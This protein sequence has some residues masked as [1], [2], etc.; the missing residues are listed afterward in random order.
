MTEVIEDAEKVRLLPIGSIVL[1]CDSDT[2][3]RYD[4]YWKCFTG[5]D[6]ILYGDSPEQYLPVTLIH[7]GN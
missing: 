7:R 4:A 6:D 3:I 5:A 1:D 2:W